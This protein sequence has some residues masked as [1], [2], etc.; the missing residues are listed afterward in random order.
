[1]NSDE[2][3]TRFVQ[4]LNNLGA[5]YVI[6]GSLSSNY[7]GIARS[8]EDADFVL[9]VQSDEINQLAR[10]LPDD[11]RLNPQVGFETIGGTTRHEFEIAGGG[12]K[13]EVFELTDDPFAQERFA[14]RV[15][16]VIAGQNTFYP[17]PEDVIVQKL[18]WA[19]SK[20]LDDIRDVISVQASNLDWA[21]IHRWCDAHGTRAVLD[22]IRRS[23]PEI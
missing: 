22:D 4:A 5:P 16:G 14:R 17:T 13:I 6:V 1:V 9:H 11:F 18:R 8:T 7:Y 15:P 2:A 3:V 19:R 12:F 23:I 21:Y 20:D 10:D